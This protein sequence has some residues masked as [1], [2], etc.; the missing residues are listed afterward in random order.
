M[1]SL[2]G[3]QLQIQAMINNMDVMEQAVA[4][5]LPQIM[6]QSAQIIQQEQ[7]RLLSQQFP[8]LT[9]LNTIKI[10][11]K[12]KKVTAK[13]GYD[14]ATLQ[15][16]PELLVIEYGRPGQSARRKKATD[17][18]GRKKGV[19]PKQDIHIRAGYQL[20]KDKA[21]DSLYNQLSQVAGRHFHP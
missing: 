19:F 3:I 18:L 7:E 20:A 4:N 10:E 12:G 15:A 2:D 9:G 6:K 5:E 11:R 8:Q 1:Y 14:T 16:H 17:K 21:Y 13:V